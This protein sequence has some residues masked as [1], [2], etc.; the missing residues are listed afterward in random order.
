MPRRF[1]LLLRSL[2]TAF[3]L[4]SLA[5]LTGCSQEPILTP[6][7][8]VEG[9]VLTSH[10]DMMDFLA[11]LRA[12][13]GAFTMDTIGTSGEGRP[14]VALH[15]GG[16]SG[17]EEKLKVLIYAQ[18][19]G[20]E[21][22]GKEAAIALARDISTGVFDS[23]LETVD[24]YL[25]PQVNPDGSEMEQRR[26][27]ADFDLN[28]DHLTLST[29][30]VA[31]LHDLYNRILPNVTLDVHEYGFAGSSWVGAGFYKD[32]GQQIGGM[33]NANMSLA[34]REYAWDRVIPSMKEVLEPKEVQ[35]RRYLVTD[36]PDA[37]FRFSTTALN[38]G[39]NSMG[40]Y[41]SLSFLI[42]GRNGLTV[43]SEIRERTRQQLE[44]IKAFLGFFGANADEVRGLVER[45]RA[46]LTGEYLQSD[47]A[48]VMDYVP[49]PARPTVTVG[50][51]D[52][53]TGEKRDLVIEAFHPTVE[54]TLRVTRPAGY[55][56]PADLTD[57]L[58]V[59]HRHGIQVERSDGQTPA[60][61]ETYRIEAVT[62]GQKEDK[63]YLQVEVSVSREN[64]T[65]PE[66]EVVV[67]CDQLATNLIA[68]LL[69]PQSQ[70]GLAPLPEFVDMLTVGEEYP[71]KRILEI[72]N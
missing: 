67:W 10:Q 22:S 70:W 27:A 37:R 57:V 68:S 54:A 14:L 19:H 6:L 28:R 45:E 32:F 30:E 71:I 20:N 2:L 62:P 11:E 47:V 13:N 50:V 33:S 15:F 35:L 44:T 60:T 46:A 64:A 56:V 38:D 39:R 42:E 40:I 51:I 49:D 34:L 48:L 66:G 24:F 3:V 29:P 61:L 8:S 17:G 65:L 41:H 52:I 26:N 63:D 69:E 25:V 59:L 36:G 53:E 16:E 1:S 9:D 55:L 72:Q 4:G 58:E 18:Q 31:A 12:R 43:E 5:F 23:F 7:E 21:P